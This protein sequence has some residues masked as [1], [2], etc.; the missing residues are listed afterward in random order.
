[1]RADAGLLEGPGGALRAQAAAHERNGKLAWKAA[2][3]LDFK[4]PLPGLH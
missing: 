1:M 2:L 3:G 4:P